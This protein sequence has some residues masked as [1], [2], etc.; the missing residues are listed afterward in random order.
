V[1]FEHRYFNLSSQEW[2]PY[3][4]PSACIRKPS[5]DD[6]AALERSRAEILVAVR[7]VLDVAA[8]V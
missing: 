5:S 8:V 6:A 3:R 7:R 4:V 1:L 2:S